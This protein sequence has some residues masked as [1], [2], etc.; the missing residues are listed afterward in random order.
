MIPQGT[1][2]SNPTLS[3]TSAYFLFGDIPKFGRRG[4]PAKGVGRELP[5]R[6][7]KS[8]CLR[9]VGVSFVS[10]APIF[11]KNQSALTPLLLLFAKSHARLTCSVV[12]ALATVRCRYQLFAS[13]RVQSHLRKAK[14]SFSFCPHNKSTTGKS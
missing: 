1:V 12:N 14:K 4:A 9:H 7:F 8:L 10:L 13:T 11:Y 6:E 3:A 2:G 5:A